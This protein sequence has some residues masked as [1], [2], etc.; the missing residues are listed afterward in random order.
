MHRL[1]Q[2]QVK[3]GAKVRLD[4]LDPADDL[5]LEKDKAERDLERHRRDLA[6]LHQL[7]WAER[8]RAVLGIWVQVA[9]ASSERKIPAPRDAAEFDVPSTVSKHPSPVPAKIVAGLLGSMAMHPTVRLGTKSG[10]A[11]Q[12]VPPL[13][14][15]KIPPPTEPT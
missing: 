9:P 10:R 11:N 12:D 8:R 4:G 3:P 7:L 14:V 13:V 15:L 6:D 2:W 1:D 5:G